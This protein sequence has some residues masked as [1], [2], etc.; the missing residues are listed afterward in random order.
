MEGVLKVYWGLKIPV[1]LASHNLSYW[2]KR[3]LKEQNGILK[4]TSVK[5]KDTIV[6]NVSNF[7]FVMFILSLTLHSKAIKIIC[8]FLLPVNMQSLTWHLTGCGDA[9]PHNSLKSA[10]SA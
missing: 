4:N 6:R 10:S 9:D 2:R 1:T 7:C 8:N 3:N 5:N